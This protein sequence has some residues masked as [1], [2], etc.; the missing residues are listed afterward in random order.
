MHTWAAMVAVAAV[1]WQAGVKEVMLLLL[2]LLLNLL[3]RSFCILV[4]KVHSLKTEH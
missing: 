3:L 4:L 2:N 1:V